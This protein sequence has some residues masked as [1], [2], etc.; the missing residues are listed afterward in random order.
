[1]IIFVLFISVFF[2]YDIPMTLLKSW[3]EIR[4]PK[5]DESKID[6]LLFDYV[7]FQKDWALEFAFIKSDR[8]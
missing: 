5:L 3:I 7:N 8:T 1:M 4:N 6:V 2:Y